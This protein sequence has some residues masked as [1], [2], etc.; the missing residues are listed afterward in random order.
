ME[1]ESLVYRMLL[2]SSSQKGTKEEE[3]A[4][5][6]QPQVFFSISMSQIIAIQ[7]GTHAKSTPS[8]EM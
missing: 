6:E 4:W 8:I 2:R 5:H 3:A 7:W 1:P